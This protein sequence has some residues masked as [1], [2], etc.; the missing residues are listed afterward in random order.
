MII[1]ALVIP[2]I[3][4]FTFMIK[5]EDADNSISYNRFIMSE[6]E[7]EK[8]EKRVSLFGHL[9]ITQ[10]I[11]LIVIVSVSVY[12]WYKLAEPMYSHEFEIT[13]MNDNHEMYIVPRGFSC[14]G[15]TETR[16]YFMRPYNGGLKEGYIPAE[17]TVIYQ[18]NSVEPHIECYF[19]ERITSDEHPFLAKWY[20][21]DDWNGTENYFKEYH[22]Y[23][24]KGTVVSDYSIDLKN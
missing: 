19:T 14:E 18:T 20:L 22:V 1:L 3:L 6:E 11:L 8:R 15:D 2:T 21:Q 12:T 7:R 9:A 5:M 10:I 16:Y 23:I 13:A 4:F 17:N 24:P